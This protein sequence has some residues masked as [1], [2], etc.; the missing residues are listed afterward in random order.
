VPAVEPDIRGA[1]TIRE[2]LEKHRADRA[3]AGCHA[4]IDPAG[5]ALESFDVLGGFRDRYR[6]LGDG[7]TRPAG[8]GKNGQ[9]FEFHLAQAV[10]AAGTLPTGARFRDVTELKRLLSRD[11]RQL[12]RNLVD[13]LAVRFGDRARVE[14][15]LDRTKARRHGV[16]ALVL[17][18]VESELF[19]NK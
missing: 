2:Q 10:D 12:A 8:I 15:I 7:G 1:K 14:E 11:E 18:L 6:A 19:R 17:A 16:R 13:K 9:P 4:K 3:C 5:F